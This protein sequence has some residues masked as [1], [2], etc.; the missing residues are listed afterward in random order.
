MEKHEESGHPI[1]PTNKTDTAGCMPSD[2]Q[3]GTDGQSLAD[4][5]QN[6]NQQ[7][8]GNKQGSESGSERNS[9]FN[10]LNIE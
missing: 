4:K 3:I 7:S 10:K 2:P 5:K 6:L 1:D 8:E 9:E